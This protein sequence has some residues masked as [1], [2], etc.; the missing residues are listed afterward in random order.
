MCGEESHERNKH[1][2]VVWKMRDGQGA[3]YHVIHVFGNELDVN[4]H[5]EKTGVGSCMRILGQ[6][7]SMLYALGF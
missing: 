1:I 3:T 2:N 7:G 6:E 5:R 4:T